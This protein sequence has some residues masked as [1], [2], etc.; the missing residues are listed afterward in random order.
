MSLPAS[1]TQGSYQDTRGYD[2]QP[3]IYTSGEQSLDVSPNEEYQDYVAGIPSS[4]S[5]VSAEDPAYLRS[6]Y[7]SPPD[8]AIVSPR[9]HYNQSPIRSPDH[10]YHQSGMGSPRSQLA[11]VKTSPQH[12][13]HHQGIWPIRCSLCP[14]SPSRQGPCG[15]L[16]VG[17]GCQ[18]IDERGAT[19][20]THLCKF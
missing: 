8:S 10:S 2:P 11:S 15:I 18:T 19:Y 6:P 1:P 12:H 20:S 13:H 14:R 4:L 16:F 3:L 5:F 7:S 17:G 9:Q